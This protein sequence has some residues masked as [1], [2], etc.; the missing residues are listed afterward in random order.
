[1]ENKSRLMLAQ[2][3]NVAG[4]ALGFALEQIMDLGANN[5]QLI[6]TITKKGR[7][8]K[9]LLIDADVALENTLA[10]YL[11][12][13]LKVSGYQRIDTSH[14]FQKITFSEKDIIVAVNGTRES[15]PCMVKILGDPADPLSLDIEHDFLTDLQKVLKDRYDY[16]ISLVELRSLI[17]VN[18]RGPERSVNIEINKV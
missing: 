10:T 17:E 16:L 4:E 6:S 11:A 13:E 14:V 7:P 18:L 3:D 9:I 12:R 8:G 1:M 2:I 15:F 5:V